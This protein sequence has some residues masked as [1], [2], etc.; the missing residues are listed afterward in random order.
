MAYIINLIVWH[1]ETP[2]DSQVTKHLQA[3]SIWLLHPNIY[4][5]SKYMAVNKTIMNIRCE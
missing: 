3:V 5:K 2:D 4:L 1:D